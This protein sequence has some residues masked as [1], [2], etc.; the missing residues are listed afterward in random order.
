MPTNTLVSLPNFSYT[1]LDFD[2][3]VNDVKNLIKEHPEYNQQWDDFLESN[4]G[5]MFIETMSY[6][7]E[8]LVSRTD[9]LAQEMYISTATQRQSLINL[10]QLI[11]HKPKL[12]QAS[13]VYM[14]L[15]L[16]K[17]IAPFN[18]PIREVVSGLDTNGNV[19]SFECLQLADDGKP[20]YS[21]IFPVNT[22]TV[23]NKITTIS[24]V[25]FYQGATVTDTDIIMNG[26]DN[27]RVLL[28]SFPVIENSIRIQDSVKGWEFP[29]V[30][31]FISPVAQTA[32]YLDNSVQPPVTVRIPPYMVEID[33]NN[34]ATIV[35]GAS[36]IVQICTKGQS[37]RVTYRVGGGA[38]TNIVSNA[39]S[40]SKTYTIGSDRTTISFSNP[41]SA[42][43][44]ADEEDLDQAK[45]TAP[46]SLRSADKTVTWEDYVSQLE[47]LT[48][49][50]HANVV[51]K[52]NEPSDIYAQYGYSLPPLETWIFITPNRSNW[53][54]IDPYLYNS[55]LQIE[56]PYDIHD[57]LDREDI[58]LTTSNQTAYLKKYKKYQGFNLYVTLSGQL[59]EASFVETTDYFINTTNGDFTR[60]ATAEGG[61]IPSPG[62]NQNVVLTV[63]YISESIISFRSNTVFQFNASHSYNASVDTIRLDTQPQ[64]IYVKKGVKITNVS[65][66]TTYIEGVDYRID[67][68]LNTVVRLS[69]GNISDNQ[70]VI[71]TYANHW[72]HNQS[73]N[74]FDESEEHTI[75]T[76]IADKKMICVDN[77][78]KDSIYTPFDVVANVYCYKNMRKTV[79][80]GL[81]DWLRSRYTLNQ[82]NYNTPLVKSRIIGDMMNFNGVRFVEIAYLGKN[83][84]AYRRYILNQI[85]LD[86]LNT[87]G[88]NTVEYNISALYNEILV[89][90]ND[91]WDGNQIVENKRHGLIFT[92]S[93]AT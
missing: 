25:S 51:G 30:T 21:F 74:S 62:L 76:A 54:N 3:I 26:V 5:R 85:T 93:D 4:A 17:W 71:I 78:I 31:S 18:L 82:V 83:Y 27:E 38:N 64:S 43:G 90:A 42:F 24:N 14:T 80:N 72:I 63:R 11:N 47:S 2:T 81:E 69:S 58:T 77:V 12:P 89:L 33:A 22:G 20:D 73:S 60:V 34:K 39:V 75:L 9:W 88:G 66:I 32:S 53:A 86:D 52:E 45:L 87:L 1:S 92:Y 56:R 16:S 28:S 36:S 15:S 48:T 44:G 65:G 8:K 91:E 68:D 57:E 46:I 6:V 50:L 23:S 13:L 19:I 61:T 41:E 49:V 29:E 35:F 40:Q 37:L 79:Q 55:T 67:Y 7:V 84:E 10:L 70:I 59:A